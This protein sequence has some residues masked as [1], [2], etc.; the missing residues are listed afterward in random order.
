MTL[1]PFL[2]AH[3]DYYAKGFFCL[4]FS[5]VVN[6]FVKVYLLFEDVG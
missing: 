1:L 4:F 3:S 5:F 6:I 2:W